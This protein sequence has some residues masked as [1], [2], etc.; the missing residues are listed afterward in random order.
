[1]SDHSVEWSDES[2]NPL[3]G[4]AKVSPGCDRCYAESYAER[5]RGIA[6]H[7]YE[8]GFDLR[9][10]P[11]KLGEPFLWTR[12]RR[13]LVSSMSDLF[14]DGVPLAYIHRVFDA[15]AV[16][17]W[18][19]YQ[20][21][22]KRAERMRDV[23]AELP[24]DLAHLRHVWL[25]VSVEDRAHGLPRIDELRATQAGTRFLS[26][27]PLLEDLGEL[28]L[29]GIHGVVVGGESGPGAR[30]LEPD[31]VR[32]IR[33]QCAAQH[34]AFFFKQWGGPSKAKAGRL[35]DGR[36]HDDAPL[37]L[38]APVPRRD[39]RLRLQAQLRLHGPRLI[40]LPMAS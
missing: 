37:G 30:R 7:P 20:V 39:Q 5:F 25:G 15:M 12:S 29:R 38:C 32:S 9:L 4:C 36:S 35:L 27:E 1:M 8:D 33:D 18:H 6:G 34:V 19:V 10:V 26:I 2:W 14:Q 16:A 22:T 13:V 24:P 11:E 40:S 28:D 3:R 17:D 23:V 31:W 21:L